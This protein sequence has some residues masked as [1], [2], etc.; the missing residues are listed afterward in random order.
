MNMEA[1]VLGCGGMM[2]LPYR[3]LTSVLLRREGD[4]F[5]FDGGE[6]TQVSLRR[7]NLKW[8]KINAIFV[9][10][11]H[12]D[13]VTGL[14][15]I[16]MLSS[17]VDRKEPLYIY[18]PPKIAE[19]IETSRKVLDMYI[20]YTIVVKEISAPCVVHEGDG[21]Y[22]RA[23]PLQHTKTCVGYTLEELDRP[24]EFNPEKAK[25][26]KVARG[27]LWS[28]L[29]AGQAVTAEDGSTVL[30]EQVMGAKRSGRK[31]SYVTDTLYIPSIAK[32]VTGSDLLICEGMFM[33]DVSDQAREKKHMTAR[34]AA[35]VARDAKVRRMAMI[36][37][38]PRY[39]DK[40]L[41]GLLNE[42]KQIFPGAELTKDRMRF[43][44]PY[45]D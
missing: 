17:Q 5:L 8:K 37:Y 12:A 44:I 28:K 24:G 45:I 26:L 14:P 35:T 31:F 39:T 1:F 34:Q 42:A 25:E 29:Q 30:P 13:H 38:S 22:I 9:S 3:H 36:H 33:E 10:H 21:F 6:G 2:P 23:F 27:P 16:L 20:N 19:Y 7:L 4:L 15:G 32:E 40:D 43:E 11:T 41:E 18:G